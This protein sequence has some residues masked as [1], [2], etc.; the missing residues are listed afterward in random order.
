MFPNKALVTNWLVLVKFHL[1]I[2]SL[3]SERDL[4]FLSNVGF[5]FLDI[6]W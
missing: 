6:V 3:F 4:L 5:F 1:H 2:E